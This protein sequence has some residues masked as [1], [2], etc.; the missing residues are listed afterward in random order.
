MQP[1]ELP[2]AL[3]VGALEDEVLWLAL[4][5]HAVPGRRARQALG[6]AHHLGQRRLE[7]IALPG[8]LRLAQ[9]AAQQAL[10]Q[11]LELAPDRVRALVVVEEEPQEPLQLGLMR[12]AVVRRMAVRLVR[13]R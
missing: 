7:R 8:E 1:S 9:R 3:D 13:R 11:G 12:G 10:A 6:P 2:E 4:R 5:E